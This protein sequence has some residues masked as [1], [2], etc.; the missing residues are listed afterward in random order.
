MKLDEFQKEFGL[1]AKL[2]VERAL[3]LKHDRLKT[4]SR[5]SDEIPYS[6]RIR[7]HG[8]TDSHKIILFTGFNE[9]RFVIDWDPDF[10]SLVAI[11]LGCKISDQGRSKLITALE[12]ETFISNL[13]KIK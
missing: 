10:K 6:D 13:F 9:K 7:L 5:N 3:K 4:I 2:E 12:L 11:K 1:I 8:L